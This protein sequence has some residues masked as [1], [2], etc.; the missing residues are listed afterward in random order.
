[1]APKIISIIAKPSIDE[2]QEDLQCQE[3][4]EDI[5]D[6]ISEAGTEIAQG[7]FLTSGAIIE[8][9]I[10]NLSEISDYLFDAGKYAKVNADQEE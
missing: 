10:A 5:S 3:Y 7:D 6:S 2:I 8:Q 4:L 1:M 9:A